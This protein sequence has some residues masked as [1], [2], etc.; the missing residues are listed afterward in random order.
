MSDILGRAVLFWLKQNTTGLLPLWV[1][2]K[3][4]S[5]KSLVPGLFKP[6]QSV[7]TRR[8]LMSITDEGWAP[9]GPGSAQSVSYLLLSSL[10]SPPI[11]PPV[12]SSKLRSLSRKSD[13]ISIHS[14]DRRSCF[15]TQ[16]FADLFSA[17]LF[18][19]LGLRMMRALIR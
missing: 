18:F 10:T 2:R 3:Q 5:E 9:L 4:T 15:L 12:P 13:F 8:Q 17:C 7:S 11:P 1:A 19:P 6:E 16:I 14:S